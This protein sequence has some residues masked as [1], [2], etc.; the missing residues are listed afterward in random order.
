MN[1][2]K[3]TAIIGL[4]CIILL[5]SPAVAIE[6][7]NEYGERAYEHILEL[8]EE[9][10]QR[11]A[12][13]DEELEAAEYVKEEFEEYGYSTEFQEFTFY[14]EETEENIDSKNVI[15]TREGSTDKQV[16]MGAHIDTVDY[17][18]TLGADDNA[19]G[20]GIMLEVAE[21]FADIDT[22]HTLVFIAFGA[23]EV[24]LQG[25]NY[26]VNQ[27]TDEEIENTKA[28]INLDSLIAG[29]KMYVYDAMSDTEM[30]GDLVQD[31][32]ILDDILKLADNLDLDLNTSPGEHEHYPRGTTGPW[33][34][35]ASFAYEDIPFL[36]FEATNWEIGDGDG[37]TQTEKHGAIWHTDEDRLEVLEED[38]PGRVEER[39]ETFGEIVF[40]T[41]NKLTAPEP[42][43]TLEA[44][45]TEARE[46]ELNFEFEEEV[47]RD[48]LKWTLGATI[49]NE[50]KAFDEETEEYDGDPFIRFA[51]GPYIHDNEV[52]ATIAVDKPY[53]TDDLAPRVIRHR[54]QELKGYHDLMITDKESGERVNYE[55]KLYP[56]DSYHTWDEITPAIE[57]ILDE[58]KD[59]RY[60]DYEMVGE[61]VQ[62][63][64]IPLI[65]VSDSQDSVDKYEEEILPLMEEDPGKLQDKIEDG[66]IEDY[67]YPIYIT[68]IHPDETPGIDAQIEILE[69]LLQDDELEFNTTD[70]VAD[71]DADEA[72]EWTETIDVDD[73]LEELI[74]IVHP[75]INPDGREVMTRENIHGFDLNRDNAF[76]TQQEHK[77]QKD[78]ISYW[79]PAVFLDLHGFVR[80]AFGGGL[81]EPCTPPHDFNYEYDLY[82]NYA[83][84][85]AQAMRNAAFTST[86]N[87][88]YKGPDN[89][90]SIPRTDYGT[91]WDDG[92]A[93][94]TPMH[95]MHFGAL[96]HT[97]E[98]PGLN[99]DSHEWTKYVVKA[100]FDFIKD[101]KESVFDNQLEYL[102]RGVEGEDA[103]EKVD[104]YFVDPD[105]ESIG[106]PRAEGESFFPE[107]WVMP[108]GEDQ[109][110][111]YEVY[112]TVE[113][114]LR[115]GVI[116]EQ[117]TEDV[118]VNEEIYP[119][120]SYVIP[121]EQA[122]RGFANT[123]MWD[124]PDFSEWDAMYAE[125]VNALPRTRGFDAD[126]IQE[127]DVFDESVT[128]V[129]RDELPE[130]DQ[131]IAQA[132]EYVIENST[133]ETT[134]AVNDLLGKGYEVKII[135]EEQDEFGQ[136]DFV[137]DGHKL[138]EV[139]EDYH[140]EVEEYDGDAE[141]IVLDELPKVAAFGY[142]SKFVMGEKLGFEL[143]HEYDFYNRWS[144]LD[145]EEV[146]DKLDEANIIVDDEG[147]ADWDIVEEYIE[148][149][150][151]YIASTGYAVD[152][153]V[154]SELELFEGI[155]SETTDFTH[156]GLLR[157]DLN[158]DNFV[159][160]PYPG[161]DYLYSN[162]GTWFTDVP[163]SATVLAEIQEE[164]FY[165]SGWWPAEEDEDGELI[166]QGYQDAEGQ[167][168]AIKNELD[169]QQY[170]LFAN[171]TIN[172]AHPS[173]QFPM[174]SNSIYQALGTE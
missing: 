64:D 60:Y 113:Y 120:G 47:D 33:S 27:M 10:G 151:P 74:I 169:G 137:V 142:Q 140:L 91:G 52:T 2:G 161:K 32:W 156:E 115:N 15:A 77:E 95:A 55:L 118:E 58:A 162:S 136:G 97:I 160:A 59:D 172:R 145:Q 79:K 1:Y 38:F 62:G 25:S 86:D 104:E 14:Y 22:E 18:E 76:Q 144:D 164:D 7:S 129:D 171:C 167:I 124:G 82:M 39:L 102:R 92:T 100:S 152:S 48:N 155:Q 147:H 4:A 131:Y 158:N 170:Y 80:G 101:N 168:M 150:M 31:N 65:V 130:P 132:D 117:L 103:E 66:E 114:M 19:S 61:S 163:E 73:L 49:F 67:R 157:A 35:H 109:R 134:R 88:D 119:E 81:I 139:A 17:S 45:M 72:E 24:G 78:L 70:W 83:L 53:G 166:H 57:E 87:E 51:E 26:Y 21:R 3:I 93:A 54:I 105:L 12:G 128:E 141:V 5:S 50:W 16:V 75:T 37:Y 99:Q 71:M 30:D 13:S 153:V 111:E 68:N 34:D 23:E 135:A 63:H 173:N 122:H 126:E 110:N 89:R 46:F 44:S 43:D 123:I 84:D 148:D 138:E 106:R 36:N 154:E 143:V 127:E 174:V 165:V 9:I 6:D 28:M 116:I 146:R 69:A 94:Y 125:V 85:H 96:G 112:R 98:M 41:L 29:D 90:A 133:N 56:Y 20:V 107:Y 108:V 42:E 40:Q 8:S 159:M 11:P 121:M 149:G